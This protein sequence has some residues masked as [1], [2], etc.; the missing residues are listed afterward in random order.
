MLVGGG[1]RASFKDDAVAVTLC[2]LLLLP[3]RPEQGAE[4]ESEDRHPPLLPA[5][6]PMMPP[7]PLAAT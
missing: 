6:L 7:L 2:K 1:P 5:G 3:F 4:W